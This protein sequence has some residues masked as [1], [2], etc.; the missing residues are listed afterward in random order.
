MMIKTFSKDAEYTGSAAHAIKMFCKRYPEA[1]DGFRETYEWMAENG[2]EK[3]S[4][5]LFAD[6][7]RNSDWCYAIHLEFIDGCGICKD[8]YYIALI[9]RDEA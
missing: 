6:G 7:T 2:V 9:L 3:F 8:A 5:D 4:D 1:T